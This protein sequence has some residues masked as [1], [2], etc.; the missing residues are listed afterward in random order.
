[1]TK[2]YDVFKENGLTIYRLVLTEKCGA[3]KEI[4]VC[5]DCGMNLLRYVVDGVNVVDYEA[6]KVKGD[7]TGTPLLYPTPNR[8]K[9]GVFKYKGREYIQELNGELITKHGLV[10][11]YPF[12][13]IKVVETE[14]SISVSGE[15]TFDN[16]D[17]YK[18]F[19]FRSRLKITYNLSSAGVTFSYEIENNEEQKEVPFGIAIHPYFNKVDGEENTLLT[20]PFEYSYVTTPELIPTGEVESVKGTIRDV[21][22]FTQVGKINLDTVYTGNPSG[23][24][25]KIKYE[26]TGILVTLECSNEFEKVVIYTPKGK[27][28]FCIENQTCSTN[29]HNMYAEGKE[30]LSGLKFVAP[31]STFSGFVR[32]VTEKI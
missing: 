30:E 6:Y 9:D 15:V 25:A 13:H 7:Y 11:Y 2:K 20:A 23:G 24:Y 4:L 14:D 21:S 28:F 1:M 22:E 3:S 8:V 27:S 12:E 5:P 31:K 19:P 26:K 10:I 32:F 16:N 18:A 17:L 29:A